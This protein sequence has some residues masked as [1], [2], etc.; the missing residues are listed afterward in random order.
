MSSPNEE[1]LS[2]IDGQADRMRDL[3]ARWASLNSGSY[4][5][6]GLARLL[7]VLKESFGILGGE[8]DEIELP[9]Q[10]AIDSRGDEVAAPLG[11]A[12]R[13][14]KRPDASRRVFLGIHMDTVYG[15]DDPFQQVEQADANTLRGPGVVDAKGGLAVMRVALEALERSAPASRIGWEVL[16]N[17]DEEIGSPGS[18]PLFAQAAGRNQIGLLFE[19]SFPDGAMVGR[20]KGSGNYSAVFRGRAAHAGRDFAAGRNAVLAAAEFAVAADRINGTMPDVTINVGRI[21]GGGAVNVVPDRAV[22]RLNARASDPADPPRIEA[23]LKRLATETALRRDVASTVHGA[24][25][26]P[27]K[28]VDGPTQALM[29]AVTAC[30]REIGLSLEWRNSGGASD[31]N[32]LAAAGLPVVDTMGPRGGNLHSPREYLLIDSLTQRAKLTALTLLWF[33][34]GR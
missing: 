14:R 5:V 16:I 17:P 23:E 21:D 34:Q 3:V 33:S 24:F 28:V 20:R 27:P 25:L 6:R 11:K 1:I 32:K 8:M 7:E 22:C 30:G 19:P 4:N 13:I 18:S 29:D 2:W 12:L 31:G 26:S 15:P 10:R 9:P